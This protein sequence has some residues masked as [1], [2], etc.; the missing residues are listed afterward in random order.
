M[1]TK[2]IIPTADFSAVAVEREPVCITDMDMSNEALALWTDRISIAKPTEAGYKYYKVRPRCYDYQEVTIKGVILG[3]VMNNFTFCYAV[4]DQTVLPA[5]KNSA[6]E[7]IQVKANPGKWTYIKFSKPITINSGDKALFIGGKNLTNENAPCFL[8][9][10]KNP[11]KDGA[12]TGVG[13]YGTGNNN[14]AAAI[15]VPDY[16]TDTAIICGLYI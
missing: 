2:L 8:A 9:P 14:T 3:N 5:E 10:N 6:D 11:Q 4:D 12:A 1:G 13:I 7:E 15:P 16:R